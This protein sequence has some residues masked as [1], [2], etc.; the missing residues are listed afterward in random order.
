MKKINIISSI[1]GSS[2]YAIHTKYLSQTLQEQGYDIRLDCVKPQ[3]WERQVNDSE[4]N[5]LTKEFD[6]DCTSIFIGQPQFWRYALADNPKHFIGYL[7]YEGDSIP[8]YWLEYLCD[9]RV[10]Q[11]WVPSKHVKEAIMNTYDGKVESD[12]LYNKIKVVPHGVDLSLFCPPESK[13]NNTFTFLCN[14]GWRGGMEDRG[15]VQYLLKAFA[16]EFKKD[17]DVR[18][19]IKLNPSYLTPNFNFREEVKKIGVDLDKTAPVLFNTS[20][21]DYSQLPDLYKEGDIFVCPTRAEGFNMPGLEAKAMGLI[22]VQTGFGGQTDYMNDNTDLKINYKLEYSKDLE[23]EGVKW[24]TP[25]IKDLKKILRE[26]Y[27]KKD[28][29]KSKSKESVNQA[30]KFSWSNTGKVA[31]KFINKLS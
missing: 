3:G 11:V 18:L 14:K 23:Y 16:E 1:F 15:G 25:D 5:M 12:R 8:E 21:V 10:D 6:E 31:K 27:N 24:A 13:N 19:I 22:T 30:S 4:L 26:C 17:E 2:G 29:I 28:K 9:E 7:V 20:N